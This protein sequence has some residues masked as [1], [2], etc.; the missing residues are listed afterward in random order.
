MPCGLRE[1][2]ALRDTGI[3]GA[4]GSRGHAEA[5]RV[6]QTVPKEGPSQRSPM[7]ALVPLQPDQPG[8]HRGRYHHRPAARRGR[9]RLHAGHRITPGRLPTGRARPARKTFAE[10]RQTPVPPGATE[11]ASVLPCG[12]TPAPLVT[13]S[14][15]A[16]QRRLSMTHAAL[17]NAALF[18][19]LVFMTLLLVAFIG[20]VI[21]APAEPPGSPAPPAGEASAPPGLE[22]P[23]PTVH[24]PVPPAPLP[25][26][27]P[28]TTA[29]AAGTTRWSDAG[30]ATNA[31]PPVY[32]GVRPAK[33][34]GSPPWGPAPKPPGPDPW[35]AE[36]PP[37]GWRQSP[38]ERPAP[39]PGWRPASSMPQPGTPVP[40]G[41]QAMHSRHGRGR[42]SGT[43]RSSSARSRATPTARSAVRSTRLSQ[44]RPRH[45]GHPSPDRDESTRAA[46]DAVRQDHADSLRTGAGMVRHR[47][48]ART[49]A[50][51]GGAGSGRAHWSA[52]SP[53]RSRS[54]PG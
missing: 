7:R 12:T 44:D 21:V 42:L 52:C 27:Q 2:A 37:P 24:A 29:T 20:A 54:G 17:M 22:A 31:L 49:R 16:G 11:V 1:P 14:A 4:T 43:R 15:M 51:A 46:V 28:L 38:E 45:H 8:A 36:N 35:A 53:A 25:R 32:N 48:R 41:T 33:V 10:T 34:S 26:R 40:P 9:A 50:G 23:T 3:S 6:A 39:P 47:S 18:F 30:A 19:F 5:V 13:K